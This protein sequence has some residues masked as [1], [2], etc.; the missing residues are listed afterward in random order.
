MQSNSQKAVEFTKLI[1][2]VFNISWT[3][4]VTWLNFTLLYLEEMP[5]VMI[6]WV[7]VTW[8][9]RNW[10][11]DYINSDLTFLSK[12][13]QAKQQ[14]N[15]FFLMSHSVSACC[16]LHLL[17]SSRLFFMTGRPTIGFTLPSIRFARNLL[18]HVCYDSIIRHHS[19]NQ[20]PYL[21]N[22]IIVVR[23]R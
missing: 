5:A 4:I 8:L 3:W 14:Q 6:C 15:I 20:I 22:S 1:M 11:S 17:L 9:S 19:P 16:Q 12:Q 7:F 2:Q 13:L 21:E 10:S 18:W 23:F